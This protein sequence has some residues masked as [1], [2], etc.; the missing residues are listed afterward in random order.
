MSS[1]KDSEGAN[2]MLMLYRAGVHG[3]EQGDDA[4]S[5]RSSHSSRSSQ[6]PA[7]NAGLPDSA[8]LRPSTQDNTQSRASNKK[9]AT[10]AGETRYDGYGGYDDSY[11]YSWQTYDVFA[12]TQPSEARDRVSDHTI[13]SAWSPAKQGASQARALVVGQD[14]HL[15]AC[16]GVSAPPLVTGAITGA[17]TGVAPD[18]NVANVSVEELNNTLKRQQDESEALKRR[19]EETRRQMEVVRKNKRKVESAMLPIDG[20]RA[21]LQLTR[22]MMRKRSR[23]PLSLQSSKPFAFPQ[24]AFTSGFTSGSASGSAS[25]FAPPNSIA[26]RLRASANNASNNASRTQKRGAGKGRA[27]ATRTKSLP[28]RRRNAVYTLETYK[29][30]EP[31]D[32]MSIPPQRAKMAYWETKVTRGQWSR[33]PSDCPRCL[34][35]GGAIHV[36]DK[37]CLEAQKIRRFTLK[38]HY[39]DI[40]R[41]K[42]RDFKAANRQRTAAG[43]K[44][45][46]RQLNLGAK[47]SASN[48]SLKQRQL[49]RGTSAT[50]GV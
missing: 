42:V 17:I 1:S 25:G 10:I 40:E 6:P 34:G 29:L 46:A 43:R 16:S 24:S 3:R 45:Q 19:I 7:R 27:R 26:P 18:D 15:G 5:S 8:S 32:D 2:A 38:K 47:R 39:M 30:R 31:G 41:K 21:R 28:S 50:D 9:S 35:Q 36:K 20:K 33:L 22:A 49:A 12:H 37:G 14:N 4:S 23:V 48:M 44:E 11:D 13:S